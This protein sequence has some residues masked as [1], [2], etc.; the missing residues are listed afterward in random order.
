MRV[1]IQSNY[2]NLSKWAARY[3]IDAIKKH[4]PSAEHPFVLG[5]PTGSSP[6]GMYAQLVAIMLLCAVT[7]SITSIV[8]LRIF[9]S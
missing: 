5:L 9:I 7:S 8:L 6:E 3:V 1:I 2:D 4:Q